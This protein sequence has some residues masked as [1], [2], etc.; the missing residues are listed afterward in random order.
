MHANFSFYAVYTWNILSNEIS[1]D[2]SYSCFKHL[3][4]LFIQEQYIRPVAELDFM[5][6]FFL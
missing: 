3:S 1:T 6:N 2:V 5:W 4:K